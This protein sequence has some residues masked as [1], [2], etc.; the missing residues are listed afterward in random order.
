MKILRS[1]LGLLFLGAGAPACEPVVA[2][3]P[4]GTAGALHEGNFVYCDAPSAGCEDD[5]MPDAIA[6]G[7]TFGVS[8]DGGGTLSSN[9]GQV[10]QRLPQTVDQESEFLALRAGDASLLV[11]Q[12]DGTVVDYVNLLLVAPTALE[13]HVCADEYNTSVS[14]CYLDAAVPDLTL[15][16]GSSL[17]PSVCVFPIST[18]GT[19][20]S[21][22]L[23]VQWSRGDDSV[24][25]LEIDVDADPRCAT[26]GG[27]TLGAA[28]LTAT[29]AKLTST[30]KVTVAP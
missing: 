21:G 29:T 7:A 1:L 2:T 16:R 15:S 10:L 9:S 30:L 20:L 11:R 5:A 27:L 12:T 4:P 24:A 23:P 28:T 22:G 6:V 8:F 26:I 14:P 13:F 25:D 19:L 3:E 18:A 17:A